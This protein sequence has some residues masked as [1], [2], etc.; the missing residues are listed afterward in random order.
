VQVNQQEEDDD[1]NEDMQPVPVDDGHGN[2]LEFMQKRIRFG[3]IR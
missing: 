1:E 2:V 3:Q